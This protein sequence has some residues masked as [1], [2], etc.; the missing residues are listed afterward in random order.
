VSAIMLDSGSFIFRFG[1]DA[2]VEVNSANEYSETHDS[3]ASP[4]SNGNCEAHVQAA[5]TYVNRPL[6]W[7]IIYGKPWHWPVSNNW[8]KANGYMTRRR[9]QYRDMKKIGWEGSVVWWKENRL[10]SR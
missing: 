8:L 9:F 5:I 4:L 2:K 1:A 7:S 3:C 10:K 6:W